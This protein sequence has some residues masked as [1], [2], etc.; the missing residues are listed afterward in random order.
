[1]K[2]KIRLKILEKTNMAIETGV[3]GGN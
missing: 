1:M 2:E 3:N